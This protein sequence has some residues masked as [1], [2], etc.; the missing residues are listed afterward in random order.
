MLPSSWDEWKTTIRRPTPPCAA[1]G[2]KRSFPSLAGDVRMPCP[3]LGR[4]VLSKLGAQISTPSEASIFSPELGSEAEEV[5]D[6]SINLAVN[7]EVWADRVPGRLGQQY[8]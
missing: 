4:G 3:A 6:H 2:T 1:R 5:L 7:L 8:P